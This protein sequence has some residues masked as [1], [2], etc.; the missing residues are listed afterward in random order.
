MRDWPLIAFGFLHPAVLGWVAAALVPILIHL[1]SRRRYR[2]EAWAAM[3]F[4]E[5]AVERARRRILLRQWLL[6][7][8]RAAVIVLAVLAAAEP[9]LDR[10]TAAGPSR[11]RT[12]H[13]LILDVSF[14]MDYRRG[15]ETLLERAKRAASEIV[16]QA[17]PGDAFSVVALA[18]PPRVIVGTAAGRPEDVL[19]EIAALRQT[20]TTADLTATLA[21]TERLL[22]RNR[23]EN[24]SLGEVAVHLLTD[25]QR[26]TWQPN[27]IS[28]DPEASSADS[29]AGVSSDNATSRVAENPTSGDAEGESSRQLAR[30][31]RRHSVEVIDVGEQPRPNVAIASL[32]PGEEASL[33]EQLLV[34]GRTVPL[35]VVLRTFGAAAE[36]PRQV[37]LLVDDRAIA[38]APVE[39]LPDGRSTASLR[40]R[41]TRPGE[42]AIEARLPAEQAADAE[43]QL[44]IDDRRFLALKIRRQ[45]RILC[46]DGIRGDEPFAGSADYIT[47]ALLDREAGSAWHV[48]RAGER[49][50]TERDLAQYDAI[51]ACDVAR[52]TDGETAILHDYVRRGGCLLLVLGPG[53]DVASYDRLLRGSVPDRAAGAR[54]PLMNVRL[55]RIARSEQGA[56]D[57]LNHLHPMVSIFRGVAGAGLRGVPVMSYAKMRLPAGSPARVVL[58]EAGTGDP[59]LI[60]QT[61][62]RGR[63]V[64]LGTATHPSWSALPLLPDFVPLVREMLAYCL[65]DRGLE[66]N[67]LVSRPITGSLSAVGSGGAPAAASNKVVVS[68][69]DGQRRELPVEGSGADRRW[70]LPDPLLSGFYSAHVGADDEQLYAVN[71]D[72]SESDLQSVGAARLRSA[73]GGDV[74]V[75]SL[76]DWAPSAKLRQ[77]T[78]VGLGRL[79]LLL[80]LLALAAA[81]S[82][83]GLSWHMQRNGQ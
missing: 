5:A 52:W 27:A 38:R 53:A 82:E 23:E 8:L 68:G 26:I 34:V 66:R 2:V 6:M 55:D 39:V 12:H 21:E 59:L 33:G 45:L 37:E 22:R 69:P 71:V 51:V 17:P 65:V 62:D 83:L 72:I 70:R 78:S 24:P 44:T 3:R 15:K 46:V 4:L 77:T 36:A 79:P 29:R 73:L 43:G 49:A 50:I 81:V 20:H 42:Y 57:P 74:R 64:L 9:F 19:A 1:L 67:T 25:L 63:M 18:T 47:A 61:V 75:T 13:V 54:G 28:R 7:L 32:V 48:D 56:I 14:S 30:W 35:T 31:A 58:A 80:L 60:E 11:P 40:H 76:A 10:P 16:E 41:F